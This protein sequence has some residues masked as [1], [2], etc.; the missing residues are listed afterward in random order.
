MNRMLVVEEDESLNQILEGFRSAAP[1]RL[2]SVVT[3]SGEEALDLLD[4]EEFDIVLVDLTLPGM[5]GIELLVRTRE[6][7]PGVKTYAMSSASTP[8]L[9]AAA[10]GS[11][12]V[13]IL[14]KPLDFEVL[15]RALTG[16][17][18]EPGRLVSLEGDFD[19]A[20]LCLL[21]ALTGRAGGIQAGKNG[22]KGLLVLSEGA[23]VHASTGELQG[24][25]AFKR[26]LSWK[27]L[28]F[29]WMSAA[30]ASHLE[31]NIRLDTGWLLKIAG[32][33]QRPPVEDPG[34]HR[35]AGFLAEVH[36]A[37]LLSLLEKKR[38]SGTLTVT[39]EGRC[40]ILVFREGQIAEADTGD[41]HGQAAIHEIR[42]WTA[43]RAAYSA[44]AHPEAQEETA[45]GRRAEDLEKLLDELMSEAG[46][47]LATG[48]VRLSEDR[49]LAESIRDPLFA[50]SLSVYSA[51]VKSHLVAAELMGGG[52]CGSSEDFLITLEN[53]YILVRMLGPDHFHGAVLAKPA[54]PALTRLLMQRFEPL[55]REALDRAARS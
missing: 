47:I 55:F 30:S 4:R 17:A 48:I 39:A 44:G 45:A 12:A 43:V 38:E 15:L 9:K 42:S 5:D 51:V 36:L 53:G 16:G 34:P 8:D 37:D 50:G 33:R 11:G 14:R 3:T 2:A 23:L 54:I 24:L 25:A 26:I 40:G 31:Q 46:E 27:P 20:D 18:D 13:E 28:E 52:A 35:A 32:W 49:L 19:A 6:L 29:D 7:H 10:L 21:G 1:D 41:A 22:S